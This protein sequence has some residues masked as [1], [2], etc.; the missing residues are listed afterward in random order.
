MEKKQMKAGDDG[1]TELN[2]VVRRIRDV[3]CQRLACTSLHFT[4]LLY[5][6]VISRPDN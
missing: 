6:G 3:C 1:V 2:I 4:A 5:E